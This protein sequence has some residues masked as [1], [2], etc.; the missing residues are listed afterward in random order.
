MKSIFFKSKI[1]IALVAVAMAMVLL[2]IT[3]CPT[4]L[5]VPQQLQAPTNL[6]VDAGLVVTWD[7][8]DGA[9]SYRVSV[10][11]V[12]HASDNNAFNIIYLNIFTGSTVMVAV[13][14]VAATSAGV[15]NSSFSQ[16]ITFYAGG[17]N[18]PPPPPPPPTP[19][20]EPITALEWSSIKSATIEEFSAFNPNPNYTAQTNIAMRLPSNIA[21]ILAPEVNSLVN[22]GLI[23]AGQALLINI[24]L[25]TMDFNTFMPTFELDAT[26]DG[27]YTRLDSAMNQQGQAVDATTIYLEVID[28][29]SHLMGEI[30]SRHSLAVYFDPAFLDIY[31]PNDL[32]AL[33]E[34]DF[35]RQMLDLCAPTSITSAWGVALSHALE[36]NNLP[37]PPQLDLSFSELGYFVTEDIVPR[38]ALELFTQNAATNTLYLQ[39]IALIN[40][41]ALVWL[42][43]LPNLILDAIIDLLPGIDAPALAILGVLDAIENVQLQDLKLI[44]DRDIIVGIDTTASA[45]VAFGDILNLLIVDDALTG[46]Y[47]NLFGDI[48]IP[49]TFVITTDFTYGNASVILPANVFCIESNASPSLET[50][51]QIQAG[52][53]LEDVKNIVGEYSWSPPPNSQITFYLYS[54]WWDD[55]FNQDVILLTVAIIV[56]NNGDMVVGLAQLA[57]RGQGWMLTGANAWI[58][59]NRYINNLS[60]TNYHLSLQSFD[61]A[62]TKLYNKETFNFFGASLYLYESKT[63]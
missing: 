46:D 18:F 22:L 24:A 45:M 49:V 55:I 6:A 54:W 59:I 61:T 44:H 3:A 5:P 17:N 15:E 21:G 57:Y 16:S 20:P 9:V 23:N 62:F 35:V 31:D 34:F 38:I 63:S 50:M 36:H 26:V 41:N 25:A 4:I 32:N 60:V 14:A 1:K 56:D 2:F 48:L 52:F 19:P 12:V 42:E 8:V 7:K 28:R 33:Y 58:T 27:L 37:L 47:L 40:D 13:M 10:N 39:E 51:Q 53:S 43:L 11:G 30:E 29:S